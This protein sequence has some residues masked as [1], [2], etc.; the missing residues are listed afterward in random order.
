MTTTYIKDENQDG[1]D[2]SYVSCLMMDHPD[3]CTKRARDDVM[4][5]ISDAWKNLN[6]ECLFDSHFHKTFTKASLNLARM[7]PLMYSYD[8]NNSL[9]GLEGLLHSLLFEK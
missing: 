1:N 9:P 6:Q 5:K 2:G 7:V 3:Y 4:N 8:D